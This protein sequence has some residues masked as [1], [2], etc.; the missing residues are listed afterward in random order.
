MPRY[1]AQVTIGLAKKDDSV[2]PYVA[3]HTP[4]INLP[5]SNNVL[6][7]KQQKGF[8]YFKSNTSDS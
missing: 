3:K 7:L 8:C 1:I 5:S 4:D 6:P 2:T